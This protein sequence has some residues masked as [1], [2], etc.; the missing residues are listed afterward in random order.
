MKTLVCLLLGCGE[1]SADGI[2]CWPHRQQADSGELWKAVQ[3]EDLERE[4]EKLRRR[5]GHEC[6]EHPRVEREL[7][8]ES[9][10]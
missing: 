9:D 1:E 8:D 10:D 3:T 5:T 4:A 7:W 6:P 2:Y